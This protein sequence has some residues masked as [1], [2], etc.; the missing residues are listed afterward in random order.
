MF[1]GSHNLERG[2]HLALIT[3]IGGDGNAYT[4]DDAT[5]FHETVPPEYC[6]WCSGWKR[7]GWQ[8]SGSARRDST[9][10][11]KW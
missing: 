11:G 10:S 8:R 4:T 6:R 7:I 1:Q 9:P 3:R 2:D 5:V